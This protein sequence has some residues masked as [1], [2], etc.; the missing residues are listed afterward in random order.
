MGQ[1]SQSNETS[2]ASVPS[3]NPFVPIPG[4][5]FS[6]QQQWINRA[7]R[8]LT[9]HPEY[10]NAEHADRLGWRGY[11]WT[12]MCFDQLGRRCRNGGDFQRA[13]DDGAY[14]VWWVWPDQIHDLI[15]P[16]AERSDAAEGDGSSSICTQNKDS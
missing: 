7:S 11:H 5:S 1:T 12:T 9:S 3:A 14:P 4:Q 8:V 16:P 13:E 10:F 2:A 15:R 6:C